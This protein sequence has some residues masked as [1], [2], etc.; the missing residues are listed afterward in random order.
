MPQSLPPLPACQTG[1]IF[2][3]GDGLGLG[4]GHQGWREAHTSQAVLH[5]L[6]NAHAFLVRRKSTGSQRHNF[7]VFVCCWVPSAAATAVPVPITCHWDDFWKLHTTIS[8]HKRIRRFD[9][10]SGYG[11]LGGT[12]SDRPREKR[13]ANIKHKAGTDSIV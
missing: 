9:F 7:C 4:G 3:S 11:K 2:L 12:A 6:R 10:C 13:E 8:V 1:A 5:T